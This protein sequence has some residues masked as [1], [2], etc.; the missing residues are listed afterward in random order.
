[1]MLLCNYWGGDGGNRA[2]DILVDGEKVATQQLEGDKPGQF[3]DV[4][5]SIPQAMTQGKEKVTVKFQAHPGAIAGG[6]FEC[7]TLIKT[8]GAS[9]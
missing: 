1:M 5:Y 4:I 8:D 7:R 6:V 3:F 2:F 9:K